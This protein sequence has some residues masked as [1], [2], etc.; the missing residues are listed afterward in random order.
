M[1]WL[2]EVKYVIQTPKGR[3]GAGKPVSYGCALTGAGT[4]LGH[5]AHS[6]PQST[7]MEQGG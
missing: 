6:N 3:D 2:V 4:T 7:L 1:G 5:G